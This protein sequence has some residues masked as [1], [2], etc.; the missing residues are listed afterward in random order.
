[1]LMI[2]K[3]FVNMAYTTTDCKFSLTDRLLWS[4]LAYK[5]RWS[6]QPDISSISRR[7]GMD[8]ETVSRGIARITDF[9]FMKEGRV[10][11]PDIDRAW[12]KYRKGNFEHWSQEFRYWTCYIRNTNITDNPL[13]VHD[14]CLWS[15]IQHNHLTH[16]GDWKISYLSKVLSMN[17]ATVES[18]L[19]RLKEA[20]YLEYELN[21]LVIDLYDELLKDEFALLLSSDD[22]KSKKSGKVRVISKANKQPVEQK[23]DPQVQKMGDHIY[24][25]LGYKKSNDKD[26]CINMVNEVVS[27]SDWQNIWENSFNQIPVDLSTEEKRGHFL[28]ILRSNTDQDIMTSSWKV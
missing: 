25:N 28:M 17:R 7:L 20:G 27:I 21:P 23:C 6:A 24:E 14:V 8:R 9:G 2:E 1:M 5:D 15:F 10:C 3:V 11:L 12:F 19:Q 26:G 22:M 13:T 18:G 4:Y 16:T